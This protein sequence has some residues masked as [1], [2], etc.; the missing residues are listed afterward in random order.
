MCIKSTILNPVDSTWATFSHFWKTHKICIVYVSERKKKSRN[1]MSVSTGLV[2]TWHHVCHTL[3]NVSWV[4]SCWNTLNHF[5]LFAISQV[6][7]GWVLKQMF[8]NIISFEASKRTFNLHITADALSNGKNC[9]RTLWSYNT[10][11]SIRYKS[12][13]QAVQQKIK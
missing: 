6:I 5:R 7:T 8:K 12:D 2:K 4:C 13:T 3:H 10:N 1:S 11:L 9:Q